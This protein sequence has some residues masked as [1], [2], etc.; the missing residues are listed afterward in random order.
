MT[1]DVDRV[2][3]EALRYRAA[4]LAG[5]D[6]E[7]EA[8][9]AETATR[10]AHA[11]AEAKAREAKAAKAN[12]KTIASTMTPRAILR[13]GRLT[14]GEYKVAAA[15]ADTINYGKYH[16]G[17]TTKISQAELARRY[18]LSEVKVNAAVKRLE[19][20]GYIEVDRRPGRGGTWFRFRPEACEIRRDVP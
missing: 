5:R 13:D 17:Q 20:L 14:P 19:T 4:R 18:H 1:T 16:D 8:R 10:R 7:A 11:K 2:A 15:I 3:E 6:P 12:R 9:A